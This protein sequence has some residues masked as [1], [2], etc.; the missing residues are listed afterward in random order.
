MFGFG[1]L[2]YSLH[3]ILQGNQGRFAC[4]RFVVFC[5]TSLCSMHIKRAFEII[6]EASEHVSDIKL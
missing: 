1:Y 2:P 5:C 4:I 3:K 6:R